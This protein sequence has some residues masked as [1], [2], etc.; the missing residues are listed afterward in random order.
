MLRKG[1]INHQDF[2]LHLGVIHKIACVC[3]L[4]QYLLHIFFQY[5]DGKMK[6]GFAGI[7]LTVHTQILQSSQLLP[8]ITPAKFLGFVTPPPVSTIE[9]DLQFWIYSTS[10]ITSTFGLTPL[11]GSARTHSMEAPLRN[12]V[13]AVKWTDRFPNNNISEWVFSECSIDMEVSLAMYDLPEIRAARDTWAAA[14]ARQYKVIS[15]GRTCKIHQ[16]SPS[17]WDYEWAR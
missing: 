3:S 13:A 6:A 11:S 1:K 15:R 8:S 7:V 10:L 16:G 14:I 5:L 12:T 4:S 9:S 17:L 2:F